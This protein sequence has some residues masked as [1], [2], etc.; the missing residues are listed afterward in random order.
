ME[1]PFM[2]ILIRECDDSKEGVVVPEIPIFHGLYMTVF[3]PPVSGTMSDVIL[4]YATQQQ[5]GEDERGA[6]APSSLHRAFPG[7]DPELIVPL[8]YNLE[9]I[10][11]IQIFTY[12]N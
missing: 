7:V 8:I 3:E 5:E 10:S 6:E 9:S 4:P 2:F 11:T 12:F 1:I